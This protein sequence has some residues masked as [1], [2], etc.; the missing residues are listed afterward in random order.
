MTLRA[1]L[2]GSLRARLILGAAAMLLPLALL[3]IG[4]FIS[5]EN[6]LGSFIEITEETIEEIQPNNNIQRNILEARNFL[7]KDALA[8]EDRNRLFALKAKEVDGGFAMLLKA[9]FGTPAEKALII[10]ARA[11]WRKAKDEMQI[12]IRVAD[13]HSDPVAR[14]ALSRIDIRIGMALTEMQRANEIDLEEIRSELTAAKAGRLRGLVLVAV[15]F[16]LGV[17][18]AVAIGTMLGR[19]ILGP[20]NTLGEGAHRLGAGDL[21]F[22]V[23]LS[24]DDELGQL[25]EAFDIMAR[26]LEA[27][28]AAL[29]SLATHDSLTGLYNRRELFR[30]LDEEIERSKRYDF[31]FSVLMIDIDHFKAVN[32]SLGHQA[33]DRVLYGL[34]ER[35]VDAVRPV[36]KVGRYGGEEFVVILPQTDSAGALA[37]AERIRHAV[38]DRPLNI[39]D[40]QSVKLT[41]SIGMAMF[42]GDAREGDDLVDQAD[43]ALYEAK[44]GGRNST[45]RRAS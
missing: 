15:A 28:Q 21:S 3:A 29:A 5:L 40:G 39:G 9:S 6:L 30:I 42:P 38:G 26:Q 32:D 4:T 2:R 25:G 31:S 36:D 35:M 12:V 43:I 41:V 45:H 27:D 13:P 34:A 17:S 19:S 23:E 16:V 22:R 8:G 1:Y 44:E 37:A 33:G 20:L 18:G 11:R 7:D 10:R 14:A 24:D